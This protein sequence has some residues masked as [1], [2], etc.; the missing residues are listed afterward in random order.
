MEPIYRGRVAVGVDDDH[1]DEEEV[2]EEGGVGGFVWGD[3][4]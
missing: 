4:G 3:E 1:D 2:A